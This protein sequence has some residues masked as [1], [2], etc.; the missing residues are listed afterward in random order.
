MTERLPTVGGDDGT[1]ASVLNAFLA[2]SHSATGTINATA[3]VFSGT[4]TIDGDVTLYRSAANVL[5]TDDALHIGTGVLKLLGSNPTLAA[6]Q[7]GVAERSN[8]L[9]YII[10]T[11]EANRQF[12]LR[13]SGQ[14]KWGPGGATAM[15]CTLSRSATATM[16]FDNAVCI[17][18][19]VGFYNTTPAAKPTV[20]GSRG[21]NAALA[22]LLTALAGL[23]L[24]TDSSSA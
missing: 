15:D 21:G 18:G 23:G 6:D 1:W 22:S 14:I 20:T 9:L 24:I 3:P 2:V 12:E 7:V 8:V 16:K 13:N 4:V 19:S 11:G 10:V 5:K 17:N